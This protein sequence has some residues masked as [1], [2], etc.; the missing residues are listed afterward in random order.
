MSGEYTMIAFA[1]LPAGWALVFPD[2]EVVPC[3]GM[4][5]VRYTYKDMSQVMLLPAMT[6]L[7]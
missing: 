7:Y 1:S 2:G 4:I 3:P 6:S 5:T